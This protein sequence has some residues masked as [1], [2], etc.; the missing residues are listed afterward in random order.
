M[1]KE[2][3]GEKWEDSFSRRQVKKAIQKKERLL[4]RGSWQ[5]PET[6]AWWKNEI[7]S[8]S[9]PQVIVQNRNS[10]CIP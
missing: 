10:V 7:V 1:S 6:W 3:M 5:V 8:I 9:L 4:V 2:R